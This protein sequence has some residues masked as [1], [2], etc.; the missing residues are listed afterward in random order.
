MAAVWASSM[1]AAIP[2]PPDTAQPHHKH[3]FCSS[4][5]PF[6]PSLFVYLYIF[7]ERLGNITVAYCFPSTSDEKKLQ[8][9]LFLLGWL[10]T[11]CSDPPA[12]SLKMVNY[13]FHSRCPARSSSSR[14]ISESHEVR[15]NPTEAEGKPHLGASTESDFY[16]FILRAWVKFQCRSSWKQ[17]VYTLLRENSFS[18]P[19]KHSLFP[20]QV[21]E[22]RDKKKKKKEVEKDSLLTTRAETH[23]RQ[24]RT[25]HS[26]VIQSTPGSPRYY[27]WQKNAKGLSHSWF[28]L[29]WVFF[30]FLFNPNTTNHYFPIQKQSNQIQTQESYSNTFIPWAESVRIISWN[31]SNLYY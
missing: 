15:G 16:L 29:F 23:S 26:S 19:P 2:H 18:K 12:A 13:D 31:P 28:V 3:G 14:E 6:L 7:Q 17:R 24:V 1:S 21:V 10:R 22:E 5:Q 30:S 8:K 11:A 20:V 4:E 25:R 9:S 27:L